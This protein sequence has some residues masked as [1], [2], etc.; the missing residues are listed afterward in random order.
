MTYR[1]GREVYTRQKA[2]CAKDRGMNKPC[3]RG[4]SYESAVSRGDIRV[5]RDRILKT[6]EVSK[7]RNLGFGSQSREAP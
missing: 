4:A 1:Q 3:E 2:S 7:Q 5:H 6:L